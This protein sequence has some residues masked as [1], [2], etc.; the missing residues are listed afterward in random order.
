[1]DTAGIDAVVGFEP[2]D[3]RQ[4]GIGVPAASARQLADDHEELVDAIEIGPHAGVLLVGIALAAR[5]PQYEGSRRVI[6][7]G[8][9][10]DR[11]VLAG[12]V[13]DRVGVRVVTRCCERRIAAAAGER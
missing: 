10:H 2:V 4:Q 1:M 7:V 6:G 9:G 12:H 11:P 3:E 5:Q 8:L 13:A